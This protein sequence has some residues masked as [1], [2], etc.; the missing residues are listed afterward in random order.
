MKAGRLH[1][2]Q[3]LAVG[4]PPSVDLSNS[5][6]H[7]VR[8]S[9]QSGRP[10]APWG[11]SDVWHLAHHSADI[12]YCSLAIH[13]LKVI[14]S[15]GSIISSPRL[16]LPSLWRSDRKEKKIGEGKSC[17][18]AAFFCPKMKLC[19]WHRFPFKHTGKTT[20]WDVFR[21]CCLLPLTG[22]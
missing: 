8:T 18:A 21:G 13:Q 3:L 10:K 6:R 9:A 4:R 17:A 14:S 19:I 1:A 2:S 5:P 12:A 20:V 22:Y 11:H 7:T 15:D 16:R